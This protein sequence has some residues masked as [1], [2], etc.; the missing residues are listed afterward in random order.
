MV[1]CKV[2]NSDGVPLSLRTC[3]YAGFGTMVTFARLERRVEQSECVV[4]GGMGELKCGDVGVM[5]GELI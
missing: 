3:R 4:G 1:W 5:G 2:L